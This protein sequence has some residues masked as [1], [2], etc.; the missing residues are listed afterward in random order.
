MFCASDPL[1]LTSV[2]TIA[3]Q[4]ISEIV[5]KERPLTLRKTTREAHQRYLPGF[6]QN[7]INPSTKTQEIY[8]NQSDSV[9]KRASEPHQVRHPSAMD[10]LWKTIGPTLKV[11][12]STKVAFSMG[13]TSVSQPVMYRP[14]LNAYKITHRIS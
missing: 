6:E 9:W 14:T 13:M 4:C 7:V 12:L 8:T 2:L 3:R 11:W 10:H 5:M 1:K